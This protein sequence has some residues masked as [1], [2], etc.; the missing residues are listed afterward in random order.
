V[1][2]ETLQI[3]QELVIKPGVIEPTLAPAAEQ[4]TPD[5]A[6][7]GASAAAPLA[8]GETITAT[9][10]VGQV[11]VQAF[12]DDDGDGKRDDN[13]DLVPNI[14]FAL[15]SQGAQLGG[16]TTTGVEEPYCFDNLPNA[17]Y[18]A[19]TSALDIYVPTTPLNDT[20]AVAGAK[21]FFSVG[22]RRAADGT[23]D[24][25]KV[26]TPQAPQTTGPNW[27]AILPIAG[28]AL[29]LVGSVGFAATLLLRRRRL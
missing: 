11:C 15:S 7:A 12:F 25:S 2:A 28:G 17:S 20:V 1:R 9:P 6:A 23:R 24:V 13:E 10:T 27:R 22:L 8:A 16:Y 3:G 19:S 5:P 29:L 4:P 14:A 18:T 26:P 21:S